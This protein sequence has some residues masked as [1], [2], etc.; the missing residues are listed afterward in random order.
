MKFIKI[1]ILISFFACSKNAIAQNKFSN[2]EELLS[3]VKTKSITLQQSE[4]KMTQAKKAKLAAIIGVLDPTNVNSFTVNNN[5]RQQVLVVPSEA[6]GGASG[7]FNELTIGTKYVNTLNVNLDIKLINLAGWEN[8]K[9]AKINIQKNEVDN[10]LNEKILYENIA[11]A[12]YNIINIQEQVKQNEQNLKSASTLF[13][14]SENKYVLGLVK[15]QDVNDAKASFLTT[16][17]NNNQLF[18]LE[19]QNILLLKILCDIPENESIEIVD[20]NVIKT[21]QEKPSAVFND[22]SFKSN[23]LREKYALANYKQNKLSLLPTASFVF[24]N[25]VQQNT[26]NFQL[27]DSSVKWINSYFVGLKLSFGLPTAKS[28]SQ[29]YNAKFDYQLAQKNSEQSKIKSEIEFKQ[30]NVDYEKAISQA[31]ANDKIFKLRKDTYDKNQKLYSE[32][33]IGIDQTLNSYNA[34]VNANYNTISSLI[35]IQL[36]QSRIDINNKIN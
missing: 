4:I 7:G 21:I 26:S 2:L 14:T 22:L 1:F 35:N 9:L 13:K 34:M 19:T 6:F 3:F 10:K 31:K 30:L 32:G 15:Q 28:I 36:A 24:S 17:E 12:Y 8:L 29:V 33:L 25:N 23:E 18:Y 5:L 11:S 20:N 16:Q 27:F